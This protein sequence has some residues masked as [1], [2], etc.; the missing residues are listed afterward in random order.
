MILQGDIKDDNRLFTCKLTRYTEAPGFYTF[1]Y[2]NEDLTSGKQI[3]YSDIVS[4]QWWTYKSETIT[5]DGEQITIP[6]NVAIPDTGTTLCLLSDTVC[7]KI[8]SKIPGAKFDRRE[9]GWIFPANVDVNSLP[10]VGLAVGKNGEG[11]GEKMFYISP[12]DLAYAP[13]TPGWIFGGIQSKG[14]MPEDLLGDVFLK[15]LYCIF[16]AGKKQFGCV[17]R[18]PAFITPPPS[19]L[20]RGVVKGS[21]TGGAEDDD[22][23]EDEDQ[24]E[25][26]E[27]EGDQGAGSQG[28]ATQAEGSPAKA[29]S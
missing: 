8:Y 13:A 1:G 26:G 15:N 16:N 20:T 6:G 12:R 9:G 7:K 23:N 18:E 21:L 17:Q 27:G 3:H 28:E 11:M 29:A 22:D 4:N 10:K 19:F 2:I 5:V 24:T 14:S 25:E